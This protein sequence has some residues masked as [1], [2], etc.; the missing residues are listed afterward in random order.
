MSMRGSPRDLSFKD[1]DGPSRL[2]QPAPMTKI[3]IRVRVDVAKVIFALLAI[4]L[5]LR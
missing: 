1:N 2:R 5:A 3:D 4:Y